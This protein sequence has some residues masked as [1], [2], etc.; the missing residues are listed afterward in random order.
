MR[1]EK[2]VLLFEDVKKTSKRLEKTKLLSEFLMKA[3]E[4]LELV[5]LLLEGKI[6]P[7]TATEKIGIADNLAQKAIV[8]ATGIEIKEVEAVLREIGDL[9][10]VAERLL[11]SKQQVSVLSNEIELEE[12]V[13][14]L[15]KLPFIEGKGS[16]DKKLSIISTMLIK[17]TPLEAKYIIKTITDKLRLGIGKSTLRDAIVAAFLSEELYIMDDSGSLK[18]NDRKKYNAVIEKIQYAYDI[19]NDFTIIAANL[20]ESGMEGIEKIKLSSAGTPLNPMLFQKASSITEAFERVG[21]PAAFEFKYDGFRMQV[22]KSADDT[23][24]IFTRNLE[25]VTKAF[26]DVVS[27]FKEFV[28]V[29]TFIVDA[30]C[31]GYDKE[32]GDYTPFQKISERIKRKHDIEKMVEKCPVEVNVF[33][34]LFCEGESLLETPFKERRSLLE[35]IIVARDKKIVLS[36]QLVTDDTE[37]A[38]EF[39]QKSLSKGEEG[40]MAKNIN[41]PYKPGSRVGYGIKIKTTLEPLDVVIVGTEYGEGKRSGYFTTF[42]IAIKDEN[43]LKE[44]GKVSTGL[45]E[46]ESKGV[47]FSHL[48]KL[49]KPFIINSQS[50]KITVKPTV[51]IEVEYEEIQK[52]VNYSSGFALRF[53][54]FK[55]LRTDKNVSN[56][57]TKQELLELYSSQ[58]FRNN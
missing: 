33:D 26:P 19:T 41:A 3:D 35:K 16:Q 37:E 31:V 30:E 28:K 29:K 56:I 52:S 6:F 15:R 2:I 46:L 8:K 57:N 21:K 24:S 58:R 42:Y 1:Y 22:H 11:Q 34:I 23:I 32:T 43:E 44:V 7:G 20:K 54:R 25:N 9:G 36:K 18:I 10:E 13:M 4:K 45:K 5:V 38:Q 27:H 50:T 49:L 47:T 53:P 17:S 55:R 48:T 51:V 39:F 12:F 40:I 14:N